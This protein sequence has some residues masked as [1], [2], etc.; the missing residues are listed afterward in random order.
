MM[1]FRNVGRVLLSA[2]AL[3]VACGLTMSS[4]MGGVTVEVRRPLGATGPIIATGPGQ[5]LDLEVWAVVTGADGNTA[6]DGLWKFYASVLSSNGGLVKG[7]MGGMAFHQDSYWINPP[8]FWLI[9]PTP[10]NVDPASVGASADLDG[11]GDLDIG[12][13]DPVDAVGW[14]LGR[15]AAMTPTT[16]Q[17]AWHVMNF[18]FAVTEMVDPHGVTQIYVS[19]RPGKD[20]LWNEDGYTGTG[21]P[22]HTWNEAGDRLG[23]PEAGAPIMLY[24]EALAMLPYGPEGL[25]VPFG[26]D[27]VLDAGPS[28]GSINTYE[29]DLNSDGLVDF[30][31]SEPMLTVAWDTLVAAGFGPGIYPAT[32]RVAWQESPALTEDEITFDFEVLPEPATMALLG[33]GGLMTL[34]RRRRR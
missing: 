20:S 4:A 2:L 10:F 33:I 23:S 6:N 16:Q 27:I 29:W 30:T 21:A 15:A 11:D 13:T 19:P 17:N 18:E 3:V 24:A 25:Q 5:V 14:V 28:M 1:A 9:V 31:S 34:L 22:P 12:S 8:G 7:D 32:L 26:A